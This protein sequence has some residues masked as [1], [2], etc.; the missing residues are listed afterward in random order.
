M[1]IF[2][3]VLYNGIEFK[4]AHLTPDGA[5]SWREKRWELGPRPFPTRDE[6]ENAMHIWKDKIR[7]L[8]LANK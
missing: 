3:Y 6:A 5:L 2:F 7:K 4:I 8:N 1:P